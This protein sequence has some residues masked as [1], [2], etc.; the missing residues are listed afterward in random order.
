MKTT[1]KTSMI[2]LLAL[3]TIFTSC[4]SDDDNNSNNTLLTNAEIPSAIKTYVSTHFPADSIIRA[5]QE[6]ENS[7]VTYEIYLNDRL[8]LEFNSAF[9]IIEI[10]GITKLPDSVI[11]QP[12]LDF[13]LVLII[14]Y[15][16]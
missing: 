7:V 4:S 14:E 8:N 3:S 10:D 13:Q 6:I 11:P 1:I 16:P 5:E 2:V 12:I 15:H 9:E